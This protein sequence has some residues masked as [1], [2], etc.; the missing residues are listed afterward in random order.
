MKS[1][2]KVTQEFTRNR[3]IFLENLTIF[4]SFSYIPKYIFLQNE[5][6]RLRELYVEIWPFPWSVM[7]RLRMCE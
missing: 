6:T 5:S 2:R 3:V 7:Q 4:V 1:S